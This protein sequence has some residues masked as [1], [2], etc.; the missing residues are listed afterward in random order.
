MKGK[1]YAAVSLDKEQAEG[2]NKIFKLAGVKSLAPSKY[3]VTICYDEDDP[4]INV[5][6]KSTKK[7]TAKIVGVERLGK[8]GSKWEA[9]VLVLESESLT[10]RHNELKDLGFKSKYKDYLCH[11]SIVYE[12]NDTDLDMVTLINNLGVLPKVLKFSDE[13]WGTTK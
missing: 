6:D 12:P 9:I 2:I 1:G 8:P 13:H 5:P 3:H 10:K 4:V 11:M 7:Y